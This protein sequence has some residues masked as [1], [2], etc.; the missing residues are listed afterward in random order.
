MRRPWG[1][2]R[3]WEAGEGPPLLAVHGLGGSGRYWTGL[4]EA[5]GDR[6]HVIA[7]DLGGF[8]ASGK[9]RGDYDRAFHLAN[10]DAVVEA[11]APGERVAVA[12]HSLGSMLALVWAAR[13]PSRVR[14][15]ALAA[16]PYPVPHHAWDPARWSGRRA[17]VPRVVAGTFRLL[18]PLVSLPVIAT[19]R[20]PGAVVRDY[21]RQTFR[22]RSRTLWSLWSDPSLAEELPGIEAIP[23]SVP[24]LLSHAA[25]DR[26]VPAV[27]VERWRGHVPHAEACVVPDGGHQFLLRS[28]FEPLVT[29][30]DAHRDASSD[31]APT[32]GA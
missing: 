9:P 12:S 10:L 25:D 8:G 18:W 32:L 13:D 20:Y 11:C 4:T 1:R 30:L 7:P 19:G 15:L 22:S 5:L 29:W 23:T 16:T 27:N 21:G 26:R 14:A 24:V 28:R 2:V 17:L 3:V 31:G 6:F